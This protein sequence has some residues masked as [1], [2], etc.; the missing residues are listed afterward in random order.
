MQTFLPYADFYKSASVLDWQYSHNRLNN[1]INEGIVIAQSLLGLLPAGKGYEKH[2]VVKMWKGYEAALVVYIKECFVFWNERKNTV[3][4]E[5]PRY[6]IIYI[7]KDKT[8]LPIYRDPP[9]LG[10]DKFHSA[11]RSILLAKL[12]EWY[13]QFGDQVN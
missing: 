11:H 4:A 12:P 2:P 6:K 8:T 1:Q 3:I 10:D 9:W 7:L 13:S 5:D